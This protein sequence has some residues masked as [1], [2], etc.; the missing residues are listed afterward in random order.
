M[1][2]SDDKGEPVKTVRIGGREVEVPIIFVLPEEAGEKEIERYERPKVHIKKEEKASESEEE[3]LEEL[4]DGKL[5]EV[6]K[7]KVSGED[8]TDDVVSTVKRRKRLQDYFESTKT[9]KKGDSEEEENTPYFDLLSDTPK[10]KK[11]QPKVLYS[12]LLSEEKSLWKSWLEK[13]QTRIDRKQEWGDK[14]K[15]GI[16]SW[17]DNPELKPKGRFDKNGK[18]IPEKGQGDGTLREGAL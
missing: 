16:G 13:K 7:P 17:E 10:K 12:D 15:I 8:H 6:E 2:K 18:R 11:K 5:E 14:S 3:P 4:T 1:P 9:K